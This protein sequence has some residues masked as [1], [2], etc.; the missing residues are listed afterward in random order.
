MWV[1]PIMSWV[2]KSPLHAL[3][4]KGIML[5]TVTGRK[6]GRSISTPTAYLRDGRTL[7]VVSRRE[8]KWWRNLRGG[9]AAQVLV[10]GKTLTGHGSVIEDEWAVAQQ[11]FENL[12]KDPKRARFAQVS[13]D[14]AGTPVFA[15]CERAAKTMLVIKIELE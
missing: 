9:A 12:K 4:S 5:V 2:L 1:D 10:A 14:A 6:S 8:S 15:D 11:L 7:W 13:L 3:V